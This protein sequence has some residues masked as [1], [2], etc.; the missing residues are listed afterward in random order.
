MGVAASAMEKR[1]IRTERGDINRQVAL[2]NKMLRQLRA[3]INKLQAGL[4]E[5][6]VE[7]AAVSDLPTLAD[8]LN[9]ILEKPEEKTRR[10]KITDLKTFARAIIFVQENDITNVPSLRDKVVEMYGQVGGVSDRLKKVDRRI[11]TL[12]EHLK[13]ADNY[14]RYRDIHRQYRQQK[15]NK[16]DAFFEAHR[17]ELT[18]Y[19]AARNYLDGVMNGRTD[20]PRKA[21]RAERETLTAEKGSLYAEYTRLKEEVRDAEVIRR[22]VETVLRDEPQKQRGREHGVEL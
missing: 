22:C 18:H 3:R 12:D 21:W 13:H 17:A 15:P 5:L 10:Q 11:K 4:D 8:V 20:I 14:F 9:G 16:R 2:D 1:G 19:E 7:A 6:L